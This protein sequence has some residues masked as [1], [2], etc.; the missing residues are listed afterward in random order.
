MT[1]FIAAA[2]AILI[3][4]P[5][6]AENGVTETDP[7]P[8]PETLQIIDV[9]DHTLA[10]YLWL[11]RLVV[12]FADSPNDPRFVQQME[13]IAE[14][15]DDLFARD[16]IILTDTDPAA[17]SAIREDLR[18]RGFAMVLIG[19][20]GAIYLRKPT[21]WNVRELTRSIDKMPIRQQE[22]REMR[23]ME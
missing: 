2:T 5:A 7:A 15:P 17:G 12:V 19:K 11:A 9:A 18:P 21:P 22:L 6:W 8:A 14:R 10:E 23:G 16:V 13:Y 4:L 1:R 3:A 20:D